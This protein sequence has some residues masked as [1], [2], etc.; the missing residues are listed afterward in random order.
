M[1]TAWINA[2]I[3][4]AMKDLDDASSHLYFIQNKLAHPMEAKLR[5]WIEDNQRMAIRQKKNAEL[6]LRKLTEQKTR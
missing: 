2:R 6:A 4:K 5:H 3:E 1:S